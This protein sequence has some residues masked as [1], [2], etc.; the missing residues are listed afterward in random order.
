[1]FHRSLTVIA[2]ACPSLRRTSCPRRRSPPTPAVTTSKPLFSRGWLV[3][4]AAARPARR[5]PCQRRLVQLRLRA[6]PK[7]EV[8]APPRLVRHWLPPRQRRRPHP[9]H[10]AACPRLCSW[11]LETLD[12]GDLLGPVFARMTRR[13][14]RGPATTAHPRGRTA[15]PAAS[16]RMGANA[17]SRPPV[18][19]AQ[20]VLSP[21]VTASTAATRPPARATQPSA[22]PRLSATSAVS[23]GG[24]QRRASFR[25]SSGGSADRSRS[26]PGIRRPASSGAGAPHQLLGRDT[27]RLPS[28]GPTAAGRSASSARPRLPAS[29]PLTRLPQD[30]RSSSTAGAMPVTR[31]DQRRVGG[32]HR[33][34]FTALGAASLAAGAGSSG[35]DDGAQGTVSIFSTMSGK[36][37]YDSLD[38]AEVPKA[39]KAALAGI[40]MA[41][42]TPELVRLF[43]TFSCAF[44]M[45]IITSH[46]A[47]VV[48]KFVRFSSQKRGTQE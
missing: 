34:S 21:R 47:Q 22:S 2:R 9:H 18:R 24:D 4:P 33:T 25:G 38:K 45:F 26:A 1:M 19:T 11:S 28:T 39:T 36:E 46:R 41:E 3:A 30:G 6:A 10:L 43:F 37:L 32:G 42:V 44:N 13:A 12:S 7:T 14:D 17:A 35:Q 48:L 23:G 5:T 16:S 31:V 27:A 8:R 40:L 15:V 20:P 29:R